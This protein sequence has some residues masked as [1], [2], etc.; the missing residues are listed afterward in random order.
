LDI[1]PPYRLRLALHQS[2]DEL[3]W[4]AAAQKDSVAAPEPVRCPVHGAAWA[5]QL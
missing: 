4:L 1:R 3:F 5:S 2:L